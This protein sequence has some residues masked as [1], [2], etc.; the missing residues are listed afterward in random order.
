MLPLHD[1]NIIIPDVFPRDD[2]DDD[3][4]GAGAGGLMMKGVVEGFHGNGV[5]SDA[6][7]QMNSLER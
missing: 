3:G 1:R 6:A 2:D 4:G 7:T 5:C